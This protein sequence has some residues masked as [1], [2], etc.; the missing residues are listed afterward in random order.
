MRFFQKASLTLLIAC[1]CP[2]VSASAQTRAWG[3]NLTGQIGDG[4]SGSANKRPTPID[5][6]LDDIT[7][8]SGSGDTTLALR[9]N[10]TVLAWGA[11]QRGQAGNGT[12]S[13]GG[14]SCITSPVAVTGLKNVI[15]ISAG[16]DHGAALKADG[17]VWVWGANFYGQLG[18]NNS[19]Q[20][21]PL[22]F[23]V[24]GLADIIAIESGEDYT[25]A[26]RSDGTVWSWGGNDFGQL[27]YVQDLD[28]SPRQV[29]SPGNLLTGIIA[30]A[31]AAGHSAA[32]RSDG[33]VWS[34]G[35]NGNGEMGNNTGGGQTESGVVPIKAQISDVTQIAVGSDHTSVLKADGTVWSWGWNQHGEVGNGTTG[36]ADGCVVCV[37]LPK[38]TSIAGVTGIEARGSHTL[39]RKR[40]GSIWAWGHNEAGGIGN[41]LSGVNTFEST[42]VQSQAGVGNAIF[43]AGAWH[44]FA[45][46]PQINTPS[47]VNIFIPGDNFKIN[48]TV[49]SATGVTTV[50][51]VDANTTGLTVPPGYIILPH[52]QGYKFTTTATK[53]GTIGVCLSTA[54]VFDAAQFGRLRLLH[55]EGGTLADRTTI[56]DYRRRE[57]CAEAASLGRFMI[58]DAPVPTGTVDLG[59]RVLALNGRGVQGAR[60]TVS[61]SDGDRSVRTNQLGYYR[62]SNLSAGGPYSVAVDSKLHNFTARNLIVTGNTTALNFIAHE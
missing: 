60:V 57:I 24:P 54:A 53:S 9:S 43:S 41:G 52:S 32:L 27:G 1:L 31:A 62:V 50:N 13:A 11:N 48:F 45:A 4:T 7:Q 30:I 47:G 20:D 36:G 37:R 10:G 25:L 12:V 15:A 6:E 40:D 39:A 18:I 44:S 8:I 29:G 14:C 28:L 46:V 35:W 2:A 22:A 51:G 59:G 21:V 61:G 3:Y 16:S 33:T 5:I 42:P 49:L 26:L 23:R 34:W 19:F 55:E 58:A 17:T 38:Q 56:L